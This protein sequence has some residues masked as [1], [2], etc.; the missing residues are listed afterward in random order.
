[1][2]PLVSEDV[3]DAPVTDVSLEKARDAATWKANP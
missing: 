2:L 1:M 3:S